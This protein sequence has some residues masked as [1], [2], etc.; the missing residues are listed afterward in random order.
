MVGPQV[1]ALMALTVVCFAIAYI[2][3]LRQEVR[4]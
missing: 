4:A 3:F 1:V 2:V